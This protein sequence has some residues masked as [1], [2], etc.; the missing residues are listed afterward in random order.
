MEKFDAIIVGAGLAGLAAAYTLAQEGLEVLVLERG[1]YAGAKN[2]TGGRLY[3]NPIRDMFPDLW[4]KAPL[5][6]FIAR[7]E[8]AIVAKERSLTMSYCG[9]DLRQEPYQSYSILRAKFD[10]WLAKQAERKG[11]MLVT[12]S[13]VDDVIIDNGQVVG[14]IA[15]GEELHADVVIACDGVMS[16]VAEKAGLRKPGNPRDFAVGFKEV[17]EL[18]P[19]VIE[20]RFGLNGNEGA[21]RL[22]MGEVTK[23]KFGG[24]FLYTNKESLSLGIVVGIKDLMEG[25]QV[26]APSLLDDFKQRPEVASLIRGGQT[27]EYSAHVIPEGGLKALTKLYGNGILVAG[28]AAGL[29]MNIGVT[30]RGMEYAMASGYLAAQAVLKAREAGQYSASQLAV[31]ELLLKDSFVMKD[32]QNF[33]D[34]PAALDN[35][36]FFT[37]YPEMI[38]TMMSE[39][40]AV[41]AGP[42]ERIYPTLKKHLTIRELWD[43]LGDLRKVRKI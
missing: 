33:K 24:G 4:K 42:K 40:Y 21:A 14:V 11:A 22:Y 35:P 18:D 10:R 27:V 20:D 31:Y 17:I 23:G 38:T 3:L 28:D 43:M 29:S 12:K 39:L 34:A 6:R 32:F 16:L 15:G 30:V 25:E 9:E 36:R 7:E 8:V 41:G 1:D 37:V 5:E 13:R 19:T 26:Q 2:V